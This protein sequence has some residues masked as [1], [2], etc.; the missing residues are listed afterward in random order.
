MRVTVG[1]GPHVKEGRLTSLKQ[2]EWAW[3][4][5]NKLY[6]QTKKE[7]RKAWGRANAEAQRQVNARPP[8]NSLVLEDSH[9]ALVD[10]R[11]CGA[12]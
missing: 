5:S 7:D 4:C 10:L 11:G 6:L 12:F 2:K 3:L 1:L 9:H 8:C